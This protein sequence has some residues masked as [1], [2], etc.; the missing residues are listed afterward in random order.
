MAENYQPVQVNTG[1]AQQAITATPNVTP[2]LDGLMEG[3]KSGF[4]SASDIQKRVSEGPL[5]AA[6]QAQ[7]LADVTQIR[8]LQRQA[9][10]AEL[11]NIQAK[12][13]FEAETLPIMNDVKRATLAQ[14]FNNAKQFGAP[15]E[16]L[17]VFYASVPGWIPFDPEKLHDKKTGQVNLPYA[18][19][20]IQKAHDAAAKLKASQP[21]SVTTKN[22]AASGA[23]E[24]FQQLVNPVSGAAMGA[25]IPTGVVEPNAA[26]AEAT[27]NQVSEGLRK[28]F[29]GADPIQA[30][31]KVDAAVNKIRL[32]ATPTSTPFQDMSAIFGFMKV[33]DPGSTVREG[34]YA[35]VEKSRG[36][37]DAFR[38]LYNKALSGQKLTVEQKAQLLASAE[39]NYQGQLKTAAPAI[40][41]FT[42]LEAKN[43]FPPGTIVPV[44]FTAKLSATPAPVPNAVVPGTLPT[45]QTPAEVPTSVQYFKT[46]AGRPVTNPNYKP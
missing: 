20:T 45:Y 24:S 46:P 17:K 27:K 18:I 4:I 38:G 3:I 33:L 14:A 10:V 25:K 22:T 37:P 40:R 15:E 21:I 19:E 8:P 30:F 41:Q 9:A 12:Q 29:Y 13:A 16:I 44:E 43:G 11:G 42:E 39:E 36:W 28:E 34:E 2:N 23:E 7:N 32:A 26:K 6:T 1:S 35:T 5:A 31:D